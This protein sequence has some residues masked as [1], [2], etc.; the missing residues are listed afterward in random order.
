MRQVA[1]LLAASVW[2]QAPAWADQA[3]ASAPPVS[4]E[5]LWFIII[6]FCLSGLVFLFVENASENRDRIVQLSMMAWPDL[7]TP[8]PS[9]PSTVKVSTGEQPVSATKRKRDTEAA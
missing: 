7:T 2:L 3:A 1:M 9:K 8:A 6:S 4:I 5:T